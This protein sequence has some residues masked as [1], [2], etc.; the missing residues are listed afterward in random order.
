MDVESSLNSTEL[1]NDSTKEDPPTDTTAT[2][3][4]GY[5]INPLQVQIS[6]PQTEHLNSL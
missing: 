1:K 2:S 4:S 6:E 5:S 3:S